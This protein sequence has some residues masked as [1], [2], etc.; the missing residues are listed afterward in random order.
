MNN[1]IWNVTVHRSIC[2]ICYSCPRK[3]IRYELCYKILFTSSIGQNG[4]SC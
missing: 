2:L 4:T 1:Y 3:Y